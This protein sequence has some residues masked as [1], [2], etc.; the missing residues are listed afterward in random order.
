MNIIVNTFFISNFQEHIESLKHISLYI[1]L[2]MIDDVHLTLCCYEHNT[3][4]PFYFFCSG[5]YWKLPIL[6]HI[7]MGTTHI[8]H[9][10]SYCHRHST[11]CLCIS[12][13]IAMGT[14]HI[15]CPFHFILPWAQHTLPISFHIAMGTTHVAH[16]I[17]YCHGHKTHCPFHFILP[18]IGSMNPISVY[19][20]MDT[21]N[22]TYSPNIAFILLHLDC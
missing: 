7:A 1:P 22:I 9:F 19:V 20:F 4:S 18:S 3:Y 15:A 14:T 2:N 21:T 11:R 13:H 6:F 17:S 10:I 16:F 12:F 5:T 8:A